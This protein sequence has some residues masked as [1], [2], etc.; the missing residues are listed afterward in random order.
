MKCEGR[1]KDLKCA[2]GNYSAVRWHMDME[3]VGALDAPRW[4]AGMK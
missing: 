1:E 4:R 2:L 3:V